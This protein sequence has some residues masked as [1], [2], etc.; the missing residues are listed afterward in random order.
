MCLDL[1][2]A[3]SHSCFRFFVQINVLKLNT[4]INLAKYCQFT[5]TLIFPDHDF[6]DDEAMAVK[7]C[8]ADKYVRVNFHMFC[9]TLSF[10]LFFL[11]GHLCIIFSIFCFQH[12]I[13]NLHGI[14]GSSPEG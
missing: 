11:L 13:N 4:M 5:V 12:D 14:I 7:L 8:Q 1:V 3:S 9:L 6:Q 10:S 2:L